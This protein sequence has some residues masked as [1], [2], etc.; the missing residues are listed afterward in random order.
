VSAF[1]GEVHP[2]AEV[3]PRLVDDELLQMAES[4]AESGLID[5]ITIDDQGRLLDGR[6]RLAACAMAEVEPQFVVYD[7]DPVMLIVARNSDR[8][9]MSTGA[10]AMATAVNLAGAGYRKNGRWVYGVGIE[11]TGSGGFGNRMREAGLVLDHVPDLAGS[12]V[13]GSMALDA[14]YQRARD[15]KAKSESEES[16]KADLEE[17]SPDLA[18][19][20]DDGVL[21]LGEA[22]AAQKQREEESDKRVK[23]SIKYAENLAS[24]WAWL[25]SIVSGLERHDEVIDALNDVDLELVNEA[26]ATYR[27]VH[28]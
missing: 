17:K 12:V 2:A 18:K 24:A 20:V 11:T 28:T 22:E 10:R 1:S 9:H 26:I 14:A 7:G 27:K 21:T 8:R 4:I 25:P 23:A 5:P 13:D 15:A 6:N 16:R 19:K 3:W